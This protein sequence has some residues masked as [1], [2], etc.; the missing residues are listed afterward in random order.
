MAFQRWAKRKGTVGER[1]II[2]KFWSV[3]GWCA[4]R[5]AGSG[6]SR[7]PSPDIIAGSPARKLAIEAKITSGAKKYFSEDE[8]SGLKEFALI[9]GAEP[10]L[11]VKFTGT[12]TSAGTNTDWLFVSLED[13]SAS[14]NS[15]NYSISRDEIKNKG[16]LFEELIK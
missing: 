7:Y 6:S 4:H 13:L 5:I 16:L 8:I 9:F 14:R 12:G 11:A 10:W 15:C 2:A 3:D 1:E